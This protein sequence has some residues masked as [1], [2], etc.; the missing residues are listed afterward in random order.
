MHQ[1]LEDLR[2]LLNSDISD[3]EFDRVIGWAED[4]IKEAASRRRK[5]EI[6]LAAF[7]KDRTNVVL[8]STL[9]TALRNEIEATRGKSPIRYEQ[10]KAIRNRAYQHKPLGYVPP[11]RSDNFAF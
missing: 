7:M 4:V 6:I 1:C 5:V 2:T 10:L 9:M 8:Y 11:G 3:A